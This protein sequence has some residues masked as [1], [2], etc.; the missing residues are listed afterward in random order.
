MVKKNF[1]EKYNICLVRLDM[2]TLGKHSRFMEENN[3]NNRT[4]QPEGIENT[5]I[6][7]NKININQ[8]NRTHSTTSPIAILLLLCFFPYIALIIMYKEKP[9]HIW[10]AYILIIQSVLMLLATSFMAL[11]INPD[12]LS[13]NSRINESYNLNLRNIQLLVFFLVNL[14]ELFVGAILLKKVNSELNTYKSNL[15]VACVFYI[16][17]P[18]LWT[19]FVLFLFLTP[20]IELI[21]TP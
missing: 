10:I 11:I 21:T 7:T 15:I 4:Y 6:G 5:Q 3:L 2:R 1:T 8:Q 20:I 13:I 9:Y 18:V 14:L 12:L 19:Y 17:S 16:I